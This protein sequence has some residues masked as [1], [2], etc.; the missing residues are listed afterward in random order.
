LNTADLEQ[1]SFD[2]HVICNSHLDR[3]WTE[4]FQFTRLL[5]VRFLD[6]L[7]E[8]MQQVP[9]YQFLLDS[10]TVPLEDYLAV[11]PEHEGRLRDWVKAT[12]LWV[13]PWYTAPDFSCIFGE[14]IVRNLLIGHAIARDFGHVMKVG[15]TPF[16]FGQCSQ[17]PQIYAGFGI[18]FIWFYRGVTDREVTGNCFYWEGPDGTRALCTR[19][20]RYNYYFAVMRQVIKGHGLLDRDYDYTSTQVPIC[21]ADAVRS[22]EHAVLANSQSLDAVDRAAELIRR[23]VAETAPSFPGR[24]LPL[25]N[26][27]DTSMP[28]MLDHQVIEAARAKLPA[29]WRIFHSNLPDFVEAFRREVAA[30]NAPLSLVRG[31]RRD[32]GF[33]HREAG[34]LGDVIT[35]RPEQKR[36]GAAAELRLQRYAEPLATFAW[37]LGAEYPRKLLEIG[38]KE[39]CKCHP[40]DTIAGTGVDQLEADALNRLDQV[41]N[42]AEALMQFQIGE[43]IK[44]ID[45][46]GVGEHEIPVVVYNPSP[47]PRTEVLTAHVDVPNT[48]QADGVAMFDAET[49]EPVESYITSWKVRGERVV[50]D[51]HDA[52]TSFYC[53]RATIDFVAADI[54]PLGYRTFLLRKAERRGWCRTLLSTPTTLENAFL[55]AEIT[56]DGTID[57]LDKTTGRSYRDLHYFRD[58]GEAGNG[59]TS[60]PPMEDIVVGS[61]GTPARLSIVHNSP[62]KASV[63]VEKALRVPAGIVGNDDFTWTKRRDD[64]WVDLPIVSTFTLTREGRA[65]DVHTTLDNTAECHALQVFFP[66]HLPAKASASDTAFDVVEREIDRPDEMHPYSQVINP[67]HPCLTFA[68][69]SD[70]EA[71][72]AIAIV[73][74]RGYEVTDDAARAI[75]LTLLRAFE[76]FMCTVSWRWERRPDQKG[77]QALGRHEIDYSIVPHAGDWRGR[78]VQEAERLNLPMLIVQTGRHP[79]TLPPRQSLLAIEPAEVQLSAVKRAEARDTLVV[80]VFNPTAEAC[81]AKLTL[82]APIVAARL[83]TLEEL[84]MPD[85]ELKPAGREVRVGIG[86]KKIVTIEL[87]VGR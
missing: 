29:G 78:V 86:P 31:E 69:V 12:R 54:P 22:R 53:T 80:R 24:S 59:W 84:P 16:G 75:G 55:K 42:L 61:R 63:R 27:M 8:I 72:L 37:L 77:S 45:L 15:Y 62:L 56:A 4:N 23:L 83:L 25:M 30:Q 79:G 3:E 17:L 74:V 13:G 68:D 48:M 76:I 7:L 73:G 35:A 81:D 21:F 67:A 49:G 51:V 43:I 34:L 18:D 19:A 40:H 20:P 36:R 28:S 10:Q 46:G 11:R 70:G 64:A 26:G 60:F 2:L 50:R 1:R 52:P 6:S 58:R 71:G 39:L 33:P 5:T 85:G 41:I 57:L 65:L 44:R 14:A 47:W 9:E 32:A 87:E 82:F 38:W 66:T